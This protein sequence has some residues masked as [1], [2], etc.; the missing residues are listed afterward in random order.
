MHLKRARGKKKKNY[1]GV[2][3]FACRWSYQE[4]VVLAGVEENLRKHVM[5]SPGETE[6]LDRIQKRTESTQQTYASCLWG[7]VFLPLGRG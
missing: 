1:H 6:A 2:K 7:K 4:G 5:M 3:T